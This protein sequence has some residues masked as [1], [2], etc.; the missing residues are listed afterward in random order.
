MSL[1]SLLLMSSSFLKLFISFFSFFWWWY[2]I[3]SWTLS[4]FSF[5]LLQVCV[6][7]STKLPNLAKE[8]LNRDLQ[9]L[10]FYY[11][12]LKCNFFFKY[13]LTECIWVRSMTRLSGGIFALR[14]RLEERD[15]IIKRK[16]NFVSISFYQKCQIMCYR[17]LKLEEEKCYWIGKK[18]LLL[19]IYKTLYR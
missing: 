3:A 2:K 4:T 18:W 17:T 1:K 10:L 11:V 14:Y 13:T 6:G 15:K 12:W 9:H 8:F 16:I 7:L 5:P 19:H